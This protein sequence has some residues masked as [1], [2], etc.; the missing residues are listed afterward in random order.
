[1][2]EKPHLMSVFQHKKEG[3]SSGH[4]E[5]LNVTLLGCALHSTELTKEMRSDN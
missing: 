3:Y 5:H 1:M 4:W 2:V